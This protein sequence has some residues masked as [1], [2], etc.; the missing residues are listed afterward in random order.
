MWDKTG[1]KSVM[2]HLKKLN[3]VISGPKL[4]FA[5]FS[6]EH[7]FEYYLQLI[8]ELYATHYQPRPK[9]KNSNS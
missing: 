7:M 1:A 8:N 3:A 2:V 5:D 4:N 6:A 9:K